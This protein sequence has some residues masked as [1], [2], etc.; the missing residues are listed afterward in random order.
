M[1]QG[2]TLARSL[3]CRCYSWPCCRP[4][5]GLVLTTGHCPSPIFVGDDGTELG[6]R[7]DWHWLRPGAAPELCLP[8]DP[9]WLLLL[10]PPS[11]VLLNHHC[12]SPAEW[13][14]VD[15]KLDV[16]KD[17]LGSPPMAAGMALVA[18]ATATEEPIPPI[19]SQVHH[20]SS[21]TC[22]CSIP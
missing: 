16:A 6:C 8:E 9:G 17:Q 22:S 15:E 21:K 20:Q 3:R 7:T 10:L 14:G 1:A 19:P 13:V 5:E 12:C 4:G 11:F 2:C 18:A